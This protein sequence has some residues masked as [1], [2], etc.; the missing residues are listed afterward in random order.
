MIG[1]P[2]FSL[3]LLATFLTLPSLS[4][5]AETEPVEK[6]GIKTL[7]LVSDRDAVVPGQ[8]LDV[9]LYIQH[10][11]EYHTYWKAPGIVGV[12]TSIN[13]ELPE[14]ITASGISWP[15]PQQTKMAQYTAYGYKRDVCLLSS[16]TIPA[17]IEGDT[18]LLKA[19]VSF[20]C[21]SKSCHP[22][23]HDFVLE[24]PIDRTS[25]TAP[26]DRKW[27]KIFAAA[28]R[29]T[30]ETAPETWQIVATE[31]EGALSLELTSDS[32]SFAL[33]DGIQ[34]FCEHN[35]V[36]SD[37]PQVVERSGDKKQLVFTLE[38]SG[39]GPE[40]LERYS[41]IIYHP[42]GWPGLSSKWLRIDT[43]LQTAPEIAY[44][45]QQQQ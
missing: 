6:P 22:G 11:P 14:G 26:A 40:D 45:Q 4:H 17:D 41:A 15:M 25:K 24:L 7:Q 23:W 34:F 2:L 12:P 8:K 42:S 1:R 19:R 16:L 30:E 43:P 28:R 38:Q 13:W 36:H 10:Q 33:H 37:K 29:E 44:E 21:C 27:E 32:R 31:T 35:K 3:L 5:S 9:G 39:F 18:V 20:M